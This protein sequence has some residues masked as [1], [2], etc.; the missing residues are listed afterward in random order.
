MRLLLRWVFNCVAIFLALYLLDSVSSGRFHIKSLWVAVIVAVLL[1]L[2]NS[3]VHPRGRLKA[4]PLRLLVWA[5]AILFVNAFVIQ[6]FVWA[7]EA[8]TTHGVLWTVLTGA[9]VAAVAQ[10]ISWLVGFDHRVTGARGSDAAGGQRSS[11]SERSSP[12]DRSPH[13]PSAPRSRP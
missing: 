12:A 5:I 9:L 4:K 8:L 6:L 11:R 10:L 2:F 7:G 1:G 3:T 13:S